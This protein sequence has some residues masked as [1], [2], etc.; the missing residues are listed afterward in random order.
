M[1]LRYLHNTSSDHISA[2]TETG[3]DL[4]Q[5]SA[6]HQASTSLKAGRY[7]T[8]YFSPIRPRYF[9]ETDDRHH[10]ISFRGN[11]GDEFLKS[12]LP[13]SLIYT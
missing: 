1:F 2:N 12:K 7:D 5:M 9:L 13:S 8:G 10:C 3:S 6:D 4:V 11:T